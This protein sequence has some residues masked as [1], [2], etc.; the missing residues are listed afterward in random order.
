MGEAWQGSPDER[1]AI[2]SAPMRGDGHRTRPSPT[3]IVRLRVWWRFRDAC[4]AS[5]RRRSRSR[6]SSLPRSR[7]QERPI[8]QQHCRC[9]KT[10]PTGNT[11][12]HSDKPWTG[13]HFL[14]SRPTIPCWWMR[15]QAA[16]RKR[17]RQR[18]IASREEVAIHRQII[19]F[20][21][22]VS[23]RCRSYS[24]SRF[25]V[26]GWRN[27]PVHSVGKRLRRRPGSQGLMPVTVDAFDRLKCSTTALP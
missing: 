5:H 23:S 22:Q 19:L 25:K 24:S 7:S 27:G 2:S 26:Q 18:Q 4:G 15:L 9:P 11:K 8:R 16:N 1:S 21:E 13:R 12:S 10:T 14:P 3:T 6:R 20:G 17:R